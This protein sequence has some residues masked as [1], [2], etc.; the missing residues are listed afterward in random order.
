MGM[1]NEFD[2]SKEVKSTKRIVSRSK[3]K[4][5][6][7]NLLDIIELLNDAEKEVDNGI[8]DPIEEFAKIIIDRYEIIKKQLITANC[9]CA[10]FVKNK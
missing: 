9:T 4:E 8:Y 5:T 2:R 6:L 7:D 3:L 10:R 1:D